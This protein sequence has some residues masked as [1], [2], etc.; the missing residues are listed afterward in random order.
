M[1]FPMWTNLKLECRLMS[2]CRLLNLTLCHFACL[3]CFN[4]EFCCLSPI[5]GACCWSFD[6]NKGFKFSS[7]DSFD[8]FGSSH[9]GINSSLFGLRSHWKIF[10]EKVYLLQL[11]S[12]LRYKTS[13]SQD[14][15]TN[16]M[17]IVMSDLYH[18]L[19]N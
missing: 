2:R 18:Q 9:L 16:W 15:H 10:F 11:C 1:E 17:L 12:L 14:L 6:G 19:D 13:N 5:L 3:N 8:N 7:F 4:L